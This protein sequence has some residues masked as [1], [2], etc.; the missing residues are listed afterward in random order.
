[1]S[2]LLALAFML[3]TSTNLPERLS[4]MAP[5][6]A[7]IQMTVA[8]NTISLEAVG[9]SDK[10][11]ADCADE[12]DSCPAQLQPLLLPENFVR[13]DESAG[14]T[15]TSAAAQAQQKNMHK[16]PKLG[17]DVAPSNNNGKAYSSAKK[18]TFFE[19]K[20]QFSCKN[21]EKLG[22]AE[23]TLFNLLP[24][25]KSAQVN[26]NTDSRSMSE[27]LSGVRNRVLIPQ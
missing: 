7:V 15:K 2:S 10:T 6:T 24:G 12:L 19:T 20:I 18:D 17:M 5:G 13:F 11:F 1:M 8:G 14:C 4:A 27:S 25:M 26:I 16:G 9:R 23:F 22:I 21:V 3:E